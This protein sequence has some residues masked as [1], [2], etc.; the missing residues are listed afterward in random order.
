[1]SYLAFGNFLTLF[2]PPAR[3]VSMLQCVFLHLYFH[4]SDI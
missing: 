3:S 2:V 1:M 4:A